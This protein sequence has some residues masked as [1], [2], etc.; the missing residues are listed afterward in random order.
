MVVVRVRR[1]RTLL[2]GQLQL[3]RAAARSPINHLDRV[4]PKLSGSS[5]RLLA[6]TARRTFSTSSPHFSDI[7]ADAPAAGKA[8]SSQAMIRSPHCGRRETTG[9]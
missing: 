1:H 9:R 3:Q 2:A 7:I 8:D 5:S 4:G 6:D